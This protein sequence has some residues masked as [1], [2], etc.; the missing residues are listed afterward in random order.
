MNRNW[1]V[2]TLVAGLGIGIAGCSHAPLA[3]DFNA[4]NSNNISEQTI[5]P[6]A[7]KSELPLVT[8][9]GQ[10]GEAAMKR[11]RTDTG[12]AESGAIVSGVSSSK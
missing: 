12:K 6:D 1:I 9:D 7:G 11:Y 4:A 3:P 2:L 8:L 5:N 10:K